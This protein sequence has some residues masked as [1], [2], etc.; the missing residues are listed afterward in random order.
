MENK[1]T[2][3][4]ELLIYKKT[5]VLLNETVYPLLKHYPKAEKFALCQEIKNAFFSLLKAISLANNVRSRRRLHQEEAD[6]EVKLLLVL[7]N[8]S[9]AQRY[10]TQKKHAVIQLK[11]VEIGRILGGWMR[12]NK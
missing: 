2:A 10:I 1:S 5:E 8:I 9:L 7:F 3:P 12:S 4:N 6:A 11:I